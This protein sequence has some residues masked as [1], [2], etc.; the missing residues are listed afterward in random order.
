M[1]RRTACTLTALLT[2][3]GLALAGTTAADAAPARSLPA[4]AGGH[5][6]GTEVPEQAN[7]FDDIVYD[8]DVKAGAGKIKDFTISMNV[9]CS[10]FPLYTEYVVQPMNTMKVNPRTGKFRDVVTGTTDSGTSYSVAV[11]GTLRGRTVKNGTM[12]YDVG[13]CQRGT[14]DD[15]PEV[16]KAKRTGK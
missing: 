8:F 1:L 6:V 13:V 16:W 9:V 15:G 4:K 12:S 5:Y 3:T 14:G 11:A 2:T 7:G 10:G